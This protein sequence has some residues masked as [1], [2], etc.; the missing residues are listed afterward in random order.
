MEIRILQILDTLNKGSGVASVVLSYYY[1]IKELQENKN[2]F[3]KNQFQFDF[4]VNEE[5]KE[6]IKSELKKNGSK[7]FLMPPLQTR[8]ILEYQKKLKKFFRDHPE[9]RIVHG[10]MPN[11]AA[12]YLLAAKRAGVPVR[13][14]HS[15]NSQAAD[16]YWKRIRNRILSKF[17]ICCA[18]QYMA[19][20]EK[21]AEYLYG[22]RNFCRK[23]N[24]SVYL[25]NN[26][27]DKKRFRYQEEIRQAVRKSIQ[28][29]DKLVVGHVGRFCYQKNQKF[30]I[31]LFAE[32]YKR[33]K[34]ICFLLLGE[35]EDRKEIEAMI[36][37]YHLQSAVKLLG[38]VSNVE[39]YM[40]AMDVFLLPSRYEGVPVVVLEAQAA[41]LPCVIS[42]QVTEEVKTEYTSYIGLD[43][44]LEVWSDAVLHWKGAGRCGYLP[45]RF[46]GTKEVKRLLKQYRRYWMGHKKDEKSPDIDVNL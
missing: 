37:N 22:S 13:I 2:Q 30:L 23:T 34:N 18:N 43:Q 24:V 12:F 8:Y 39:D 29:E 3:C 27:V 6:P 16:L 5:V 15:H 7:V 32:L 25:M 33:E 41:G 44:T 42:S 38:I 9:Y 4:M 46:H 14:L 20:G 26:I 19:C 10:H 1:G 35:G 40:Q 21:A 17:A 45:E 36:E 11:A 28:A 31:R